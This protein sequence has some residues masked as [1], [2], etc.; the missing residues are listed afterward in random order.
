[1]TRGQVQY[2]VLVVTMSCMANNCKADTGPIQMKQELKLNVVGTAG[3]TDGVRF[4]LS[5]GG[6]TTANMSDDGALTGKPIWPIMVTDSTNEVDE[7][8]GGWTLTM[9]IK[10]NVTGPYG[11]LPNLLDTITVSAKV[12]QE[13]T[14]ANPLGAHLEASSTMVVL[15]SNGE[16]WTRVVATTDKSGYS[17]RFTPW[18][19]VGRNNTTGIVKPLPK[20]IYMVPLTY[21]LIA[22]NVK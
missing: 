15:K 11:V 9:G 22:N 6:T 12:V 13:G 8:S 10:R 1:M 19:A 21:T 3:V 14:S 18:V 5:A 17:S 7:E 20:G 4:D 16:K 2:V